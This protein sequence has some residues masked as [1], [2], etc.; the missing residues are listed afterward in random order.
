MTIEMVRE[1]AFEASSRTWL[2]LADVGWHP[3]AELTPD[4]RA[5]YQALW[6]LADEAEAA[7]RHGGT[8][9]RRA[10]LRGCCAAI[11]TAAAAVLSAVAGLGT[12]GTL[13]GTTTAGWIA[14]GATAAAGGSASMQGVSRGLGAL[15]VEQRAW[16]QYADVIADDVTIM[17]ADRSLDSAGRG[18][19][20]ASRLVQARREA[21]D[22]LARRPLASGS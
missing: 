19:W 17:V 12:V 6:A 15:R 3:R 7:E 10:R 16:E 4:Q 11:L 2:V 14:L 18:R 5:D 21:P 13:I 9:G 20:A 1:S 22:Y 8:L